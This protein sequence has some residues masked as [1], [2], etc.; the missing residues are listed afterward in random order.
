MVEGSKG[1]LHGLTRFSMEDAPATAFFRILIKTTN[2]E[3][4][5]LKM[6]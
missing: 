3:I 1:A 6:C 4:F 5:F 2:A